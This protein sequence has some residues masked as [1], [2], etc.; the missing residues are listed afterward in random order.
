MSE[1]TD[2]IWNTVNMLQQTINHIL[3]EKVIIK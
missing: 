3:Q 2:K 1:S